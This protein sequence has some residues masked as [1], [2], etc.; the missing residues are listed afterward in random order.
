MYYF[1]LFEVPVSLKVNH[2]PLLKKY[3][4]LSKT[5][6]PDNFSLQNIEAQEKALQMTTHINAAKLVLDHPQKRLE[7][8]LKEKNILVDDEKYT[9]PASFLSEMMEINEQLME[10]AMD[11][12]AGR[13]EEIKSSIEAL[14]TSLMQTVKPYFEAE[15][16]EDISVDYANLKDY[17]Y[18]QKYLNRLLEKV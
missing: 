11:E 16:L 1:E 14:S 18:K 17:Y 6:H 8:V 2:A 15:N 3:Y 10:L 9:L 7:Y 12:D 5:Y 4:Q 13:K